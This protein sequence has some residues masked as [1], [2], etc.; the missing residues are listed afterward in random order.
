MY[1]LL[2]D[3]GNSRL[4]WVLWHPSRPRY[5][6]VVASKPIDWQ[7]LD[8]QWQRLPPIET[9][10]IAAVAA[11][12][13]LTELMERI[14]ARWQVVP[15]QLHSAAVWRG[16][17]SG[18]REPSQLGVD[19]WLVLVAATAEY[20]GPLCV[21][22]CGS[23]VTIDVVTADG[24]HGGGWIVA[25]VTLQRQLLQQGTDQVTMQNPPVVATSQPFA[26]GDCTTAAVA[27]GIDAMLAA[28]IECA[29]RQWQ[30]ETGS[31]VTL[32][33]TGGDAPRL[34]PLLEPPL[35]FDKE[36]LFKGMIQL[37]QFSDQV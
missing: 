9:A 29:R 20:S 24:Q 32:L 5:G 31:V 22:D 33:L 7:L 14:Q 19:R 17:R 34:Q 3:I 16:L 6:G 30:A 35:Q 37:Q 12:A 10:T 36:L 2:I 25:G 21:V 18:Y 8:Q 1:R 23:A 15:Q 28:T 27:N 26:W 13:Q 11:V 4:K